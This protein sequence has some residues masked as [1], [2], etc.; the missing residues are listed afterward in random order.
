MDEANDCDCRGAAQKWIIKN[1]NAM[2][3]ALC[4]DNRVGKAYIPCT[5]VWKK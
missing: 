2:R 5:E 4:S 1:W 3:R